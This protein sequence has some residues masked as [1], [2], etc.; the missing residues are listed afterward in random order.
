MQTPLIWRWIATCALLATTVT[1][2]AQV[3]NT[4]PTPEWIHSP[5]AS[6]RA[7]FFRVGLLLPP[8]VLKVIVLTAVDG[9]AEI[10]VN[11][12]AA[13]QAHGTNQTSS[14]DITGI[15]AP[16]RNVIGIKATNAD[17]APRIAALIE[18]NGDLSQQK[19]V[20][21]PGPWAVRNDEVANWGALEAPTHGW[22]EPV[23]AG[24]TDSDAK[25]NPFDPRKRMDAYNSWKMALGTTEATDPAGF[26][27]PAGFK[28][29]LIRSARPNEDSWVAMAFDPQ[30]RLTLAREKRGLIRID[31]IRAPASD[32]EVIHETLLECRGLLYARG[33]LYANANNSKALVRLTDA[34]G[35]G[36]FEKAEEL[37][38]TEGGVG[39]GRNHI[40]LGPDG[41]IY[42][43]HGNN[44][45]PPANALTNSRV[46]SMAEDQVIQ[47]PWDGSM[48]DGDVTVPAGHILRMNPANPAQIELYAA[49]FRNPMDVAFNTDGE[50][51]TFDADM[52]WDV[53]APWYMPNRVLHVVPGADFGFRRG[54]GRFRPHHI[55]TLPAVEEIGLASP[56]AVFFG[57]GGKFPPAYQQALFICDW[58]YG[59]ILSVALQAQGAS[60]TGKSSVFLTGRP[61]NVN[62]GAI[63]P[64]GALWFITGGRGT[65]SGLYR[66]SFPGAEAVE[67]KSAPSPARDL[68]KQLEQ[69]A[70]SVAATPPASLDEVAWNALAHDDRW[71]RR[72]AR[73]V[74]ERTSPALWS[75]RIAN[76]TDKA[77][78]LETALILARQKALETNPPAFEK[79]LSWKPADLTSEQR[80]RWIRVWSVAL[81]RNAASLDAIK[82]RLIGHLA[83]WYPA[84]DAAENQDLCRLLVALRASYALERTIPLLRA[85]T[86]SEEIVDYVFLLRFLTEGWTPEYRRACMEGLVRAGRM[87]G[88]QNYFR[89]L[90]AL[91]SEYEKA[92][93]PAEREALGAPAAAP[94]TATAPQ[95]KPAVI[96]AWRLDEL[97]PSLA[98]ARVGRSF[99]RG[100]S[101]ILKAQ[102]QR[103][104]RVSPDPSIEAGISGPDLVGV[105]GRFAGRDLLEQILAPSKIIDEKYRQT[106]LSLVDGSE[107]SGLIEEENESRLTLRPSLLTEQR[108]EVK[109]T[110]IKTR[111]HSGL[112]PMPEG[113]L[114]VLTKDE[115]LD[116]LAFLEAAGN[117]ADARFKP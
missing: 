79:L 67:V 98:S 47:N 29:E 5:T 99:E 18:I 116:L 78:V 54:T 73:D 30:G 17:I 44:V 25:N 115:V 103:C 102:C 109:K 13:G 92:M 82:P 24:R 94:A 76:D 6:A 69:V 21:T 84:A 51:F 75:A 11:G 3:V 64:D 114:D 8:K 15:L 101:A 49:G 60:Y 4:P 95:T 53:G 39:H 26:S 112:S 71:I 48:F 22:L 31:P 113:L 55:D 58:A 1:T 38:R 52:E 45:R 93:S 66:V 90:M 62:D 34:D 85:A 28:V 83:G 32:A 86:R 59:R 117:P 107:V 33:S 110:A 100:K 50:M 12:R 88:A 106:T 7:S 20:A 23:S 89:S 10:L 111:S 14:L 56:T 72:A 61:L 87:A 77:R 81:A 74:V 104:H 40:K 63:G 46:V 37:L 70:R 105:A 19:W 27:V 9:D 36:R 2:L 80:L 96:H 35:D 57:Y 16:G 65:Q 41:W 42:I 97:V 68:R 43:A 108:V 91:R